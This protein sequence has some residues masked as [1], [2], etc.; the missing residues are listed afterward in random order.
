MAEDYAT[1]IWSQNLK[2]RKEYSELPEAEQEVLN[3]PATIK[4]IY[5]TGGIARRGYSFKDVDLVIVVDEKTAEA[6]LDAVGH[7]EYRSKAAAMRTHIAL[8]RFLG[9]TEETVDELMSRVAPPDIFLFAEDWK[10]SESLRIAM[11]ASSR[12][13]YFID[14]LAKDAKALNQNLHFDGTSLI[15]IVGLIYGSLVR[16]GI[17]DKAV[18]TWISLKKNLFTFQRACRSAKREFLNPSTSD[19]LMHRYSNG[20]W[21]KP[22]ITLKMRISWAWWGFKRQY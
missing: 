19:N 3:R 16:S 14:N 2:A 11:Q 17:R 21:P 1:K 5:L 7:I 13:P 22:N 4:A 9:L 20:L 6:F 10:T 12:D 8:H 18:L 15:N